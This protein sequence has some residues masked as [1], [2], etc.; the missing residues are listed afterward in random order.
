MLCAPTHRTGIL[1]SKEWNA[2]SLFSGSFYS[3]S[4]VVKMLMHDVQA[5]WPVVSRGNA[6]KGSVLRCDC[7]ALQ[8]RNRSKPEPEPEHATGVAAACSGFVD[9]E[10]FVQLP[11]D[12]E[13]VIRASIFRH[14]GLGIL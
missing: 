6:G 13:Y 9:T 3:R 8:K 12:L 7:V 11:D 14:G 2:E 5:R 10:L 1:I 4:T